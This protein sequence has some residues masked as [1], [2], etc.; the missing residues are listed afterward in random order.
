M[1]DSIEQKIIDEVVARMQTVLQE[2]GYVTNIGE[3]VEDSRPNWDQDDDLPAISVFE[4]RVET[5]PIADNLRAKR[6]RLM[7]VMIKAF[8]ARGDTSQVSAAYARNVIKDIYRAIGMD[9]RWKVNNIGLAMLSREKSHGIE[10]APDSFEITGAEVE[11]EVQYISEK[12]N[13]ET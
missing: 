13:L 11:I 3:R 9:D 4:G 5:A 7:P 10:Y 2:N 8:F 6:L 1:A 12:F